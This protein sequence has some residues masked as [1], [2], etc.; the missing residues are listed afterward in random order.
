MIPAP[1]LFGILIDYTCISWQQA[2]CASNTDIN[3]GSC[4]MYNN[5]AMGTYLLALVFCCKTLSLVFFLLALYRYKPPLM[6]PPLMSIVNV[7]SPSQHPA[8]PQAWPA[9]S[10]SQSP[11]MTGASNVASDATP[12]VDIRLS[13][14][15]GVTDSKRS[16]PVTL[17]K[18]TSLPVT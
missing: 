17:T 10:A 13:R 2:D 8:P 1:I 3:K 5:Y 7:V 16:L 15:L 18:V 4:L 11:Q 12:P 14:S 6:N 9:T